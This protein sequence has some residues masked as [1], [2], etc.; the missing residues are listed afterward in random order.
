MAN[1]V[2]GDDELIGRIFASI[3]SSEY[4]NLPYW[5]CEAELGQPWE[6]V[7]AIVDRVDGLEIIEIPRR[8]GTGSFEAIRPEPTAEALAR[9]EGVDQGLL[10][11]AFSRGDDRE[12]LQAALAIRSGGESSDPDERRSG[13]QGPAEP[14][15][16]GPGPTDADF[17][18]LDTLEDIES[19]RINFGLYDT[20]V[21]AAEVTARLGGPPD[22]G[23]QAVR[24]S[25]DRLRDDGHVL[26]VDADRVRSRIS[27]VVRVLKRVKQRFSADDAD[28][29]PYLVNAVRVEFAPR[30]RLGRHKRLDPPLRRLFEEH[31]GQRSRL[32]TARKAVEQGIASAL[33]HAPGETAISGIQERALTEIGSRWLAA[34][35]HGFVITGNT[36][37]GKTEA[38]LFPLLLGAVQERLNDLP[39]CKAIFVYPRQELAKNQLQRLCRYLAYVNRA[40]ASRPGHGGAM[41]TAGIVF[42]QTP[43]SEQELLEG[44]EYR[45]R[46]DWSPAV[47]GRRLP[48]FDAED[49]SPVVFEATGSGSG[50][51]IAAGGFDQGGWELDNF[52]ATREAVLARAPDFLVITTE[53]L[54]RW[55]GYPRAN[56][57]F[58][59]PRRASGAPAFLPPRAI[60]VDE[61]HLYDSAHGAQVGMLLRR[62]RHRIGVAMATVSHDWRHPLVIGMSATI[63]APGKF[64]SELSGLPPHL[65]SEITPLPNDF[66]AGRG[67]EYF[68]FIRPENYSRGKFNGDASVA[69]QA[70]MSVAHNMRR[71]GPSDEALAKHRTLVFQDSI[72]RLKKLTVEFHDA[73]VN[74]YLA[75][76]RLERPGGD[77]L[78]SP[79]FLDG[80]YWVFEDTD[81][82]QY[83][84]NRA[85]PGQPPAA[86]TTSSEPVYSGRPGGDDLRRDIVFATTALEVGYDDPEIQFVLQHH[87]PRTPASFVQKK[88]RAGRSLDDR[89]I[90]GVTLSRLSFRDA[91]YFQNPRLLFD[92]ADYTPPLN[93]SNYFVQRF[94]ALALVFDELARLTGRSHA[95]LPDGAEIDAALAA[96]ARTIAAHG[97]VLNGAYRRVT[98]SA[99]RASYP[100]VGRLWSW[101]ASEFDDTDVRAAVLASRNL[102]SGHP[103]MPD[104]LFSTVN[105]PTTRVMFY[106]RAGA[107]MQAR[108]EDIALLFS[109]AAPGRVTRRYGWGQA[110]HWRPPRGQVDVER[111]KAHRDPPGP[112]RP[113]RVRALAELWGTDWEQLMPLNV[114]EVCGGTLPEGFYRVRYVELWNFGE[115]DPAEPR[116]PQP[117]WVW[118]G[119]RTPGGVDLHYVS[120]GSTLD[121]PWRRVSPESS[122]F[123]LSFSH[124]LLH[125]DGAA[126]IAPTFSLPLPPLFPGLL[127]RIDGF[128]GGDDDARAPVRVWEAHYAAEARVVLLANRWEDDQAGA[129]S[130]TVAYTDGSSGVPLLYGHDLETEGLAAPFDLVLLRSAVEAVRGEWWQDESRRTHLQDQ[131]LR[132][133]L[134]TDGWPGSGAEPPLNVFEIRLATDLLATARAETRAQGLDLGTFLER[135]AD[136]DGARA[137]IDEVRAV[138][139]RDS[140]RLTDEY[141][142]RLLAAL[143]DPDVG[144]HLARTFRRV[145]DRTEVVEYLAATALHSLKHAVRRL[146]ATEG[147]TR[148][149]EVG[150]TAVLPFTHGHWGREHRFFVFERN[151]GGNGGTRLI[152][153]LADR[154]PGQILSRWWEHSLGCPIGQEEDFVRSAFQRSGQQLVDLATQF[155]AT[156]VADRSSPEPRLRSLM[157][158]IV[159]DPI[160]I[161]RVAAIVTA[162]FTLA[163]ESGISVAALHLELQRLEQQLAERFLRHPAREELAGYVASCVEAQPAHWPA[164]AALMDI[165]LRHASELG[166]SDEPATTALDRFLDQVGDLLPRT[167]VDA[168]P[169]CLA[170]QCQIGPIDAT[171]H[172]LSRRLL[173][174]LHEHLT[175][176]MTL[177]YNP[178]RTTIAE[179]DAIAD[180]ND[181][182]LVLVCGQPLEWELAAGLRERFEQVGRLADHDDFTLR[183]VFRRR[184]A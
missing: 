172:A 7:R 154:P 93:V 100:D 155:L 12:R 158:A 27:E 141:L 173:R 146:F 67:R 38:A 150:S 78:G 54:H 168:C 182:W 107:A 51:L 48:Y 184:P 21:S 46:G 104:N 127:D 180:A 117:S 153:H 83:A 13:G 128:C 81:P 45:G 69:I 98:G 15:N 73:E 91:F 50:R 156:P 140:R 161:G 32:D 84:E 29:A 130:Q 17:R 76:F 118:W 152:G 82:F 163:G 106:P 112:F 114:R 166:Q 159:D 103:G 31:R 64:W 11:R 110:L 115:I 113:D 2:G 77:P 49:D 108:E 99:L 59:L 148:D 121:D 16:A 4:L 136:T 165:Y 179:L 169:A 47:T 63:G 80:E 134:K 149:E 35:G 123:S 126:E 164:L 183:L 5:R 94:Q 90:T 34:H 116:A 65:V 109:E 144:E 53:M 122:S 8:S 1:R 19:E 22:Y 87:A 97:E 171:R 86:L 74:Q 75:Q 95:W 43:M 167:C 177:V 23:E 96:T 135:L 88:G 42:G 137:M 170:G 18:V 139:W 79:E 151:A 101:F 39:G 111:Y 119:K 60:V 10:R 52:A 132:H 66:E 44:G 89:P 3:R 145:S 175:R 40:L 72:S 125:R 62:L 102:L 55:L 178:S 41:L 57:L 28:H 160:A 36:G 92:P 71:R 105:L 24:E 33:G 142:G 143:A 181:G 68:L 30:R 138:Y 176:G 157:P 174:A 124:V 6:Q 129:V 131:F 26:Y 133:A 61:I 37:S 25:L 162:E 9:L 56:D 147:Y 58:G 14:S 120:D 70:I 20:F 85:R